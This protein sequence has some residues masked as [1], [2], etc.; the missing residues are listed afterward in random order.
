ML[1][2]RH[3]RPSPEDRARMA[4]GLH[5][6]ALRIA[7]EADFAFADQPLAHPG[8]EARHEHRS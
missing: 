3:P 8:P 7:E 4:E 1:I 2:E 5:E 6:M